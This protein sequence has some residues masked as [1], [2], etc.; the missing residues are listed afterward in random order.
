MGLNGTKGPQDKRR[1]VVT[2]EINKTRRYSLSEDG[3][4]A[5][6]LICSF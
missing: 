4:I 2:M 5:Q 1:K 6:K 3:K